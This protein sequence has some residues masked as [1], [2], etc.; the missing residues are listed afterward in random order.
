MKIINVIERSKRTVR[1][2]K[3][4]IRGIENY[5][6][7]VPRSFVIKHLKWEPKKDE[8]QPIIAE[9]EINGKT[10]KALVYYKV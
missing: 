5:S 8:I 4:D 3:R 1:L 7:T 9:I 10:V 6:I 2:Q